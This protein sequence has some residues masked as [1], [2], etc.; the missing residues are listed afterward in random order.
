MGFQNEKDHPE[1]ALS[2][3]EINYA[4]RRGRGGRRPDPAVQADLPPGG[5]AHG[6]DCLVPAQA[7]GRCE[8]QR[9][10]HE[11]LDQQENKNLFWDPK[12]EEQ[13]RSLRGSSWIVADA[14]Q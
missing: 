13:L 1:V 6:T 4:L 14:R 10:A 5:D 8:R 7:R 2:Q 9:H 12:G 3:F 11:R